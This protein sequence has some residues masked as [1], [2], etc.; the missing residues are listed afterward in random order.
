MWVIK[1]RSMTGRTGSTR[2]PSASRTFTRPKAGM[3][4]ATGSM[5]V[6]RAS[7]SNVMSATQTI[8]L[9]IE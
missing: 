4:F 7:S 8:G 6:K 5:R 2:R 9:V 1:S 3:Y